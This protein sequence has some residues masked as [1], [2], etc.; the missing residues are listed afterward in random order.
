MNPQQKAE[1]APKLDLTELVG[2]DDPLSVV[3]GA[4]FAG[5]VAL[6]IDQLREEMKPEPIPG[7][8]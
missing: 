6:G 2:G 4:L 7:L 8:D 3:K 5:I 1:R